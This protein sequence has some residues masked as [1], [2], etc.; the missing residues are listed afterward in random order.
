[1]VALTLA[2]HPRDTNSSAEHGCCLLHAT[3]N[4]LPILLFLVRLIVLLL[5][6]LLLSF[7]LLAPELFF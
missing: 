2:V 1:M 6:L 7:N 4:S 5:P 3:D